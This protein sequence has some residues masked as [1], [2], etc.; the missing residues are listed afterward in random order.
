M[1]LKDDPVWTEVGEKEEKHMHRIGWEVEGGG[2]ASK[3]PMA[4]REGS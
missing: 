4:P 1:R 2:F 3:L